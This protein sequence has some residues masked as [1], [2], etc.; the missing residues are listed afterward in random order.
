[1]SFVRFNGSAILLTANR[2][3]I[4]NC[5]LG[6]NPA[7]APGLGNGAG[8][9]IYA[10]NSRIG[11]AASGTGNTIAFN[12]FAGVVVATG[13]NNAIRG[14][15]IH[16]NGGLGIDLD[17][18]GVTP[19]GSAG[20][21]ANNRQSFPVLS[22]SP[23]A[24]QVAGTLEAAPSSPFTIE[25]FANDVCDSSG[26]GEGRA[27]FAIIDVVTDASGHASFTHALPSFVTTGNSITA[28]TTDAAGNTSEFSS[29][30]A[31]TPLRIE[32]ITRLGPGGIQLGGI[33]VPNQ[34]HTVEILSN[35]SGNAIPV[36]V[37][38]MADAEGKWQYIDEQAS[39]SGERFYRLRYP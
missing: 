23:G 2:C 1:M 22:T 33:G 3:T 17:G 29:C 27:L 16:S 39:V 18:D 35:V 14:N 13:V 21:G 20:S 5:Y 31:V 10:S 30:I 4:E 11:G 24:N 8:I 19:N 28:T 36:T 12:N 25:L 6:T 38:I 32:S 34:P 15:S 37:T 9:Y 7:G 26:H